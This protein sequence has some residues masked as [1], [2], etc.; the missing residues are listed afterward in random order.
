[1]HSGYYLLR[2]RCIRVIT[3]SE[4]GAFGLL[5]TQNSLSILFINENFPEELKTIF[6]INRSM[7][8]YETRSS[9]VFHIPKAK[10]SRFG[11]SALPYDGANLWNKF[12][13]ALFIKNLI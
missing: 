3:Y 1:M 7:H 4:K 6:V 10:T 9:M 11:L 5:L 12:Y 8:S 2:K 13:H